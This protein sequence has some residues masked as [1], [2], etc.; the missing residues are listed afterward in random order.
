MNNVLCVDCGKPKAR[1]RSDSLRCRSC[2][3]SRKWRS[4]VLQPSPTKRA[5]VTCEVCGTIFEVI[6]A[7]IGKARTCSRPCAHELKRR[8]RGADHPLRKPPITITCVN[9]DADFEAKPCYAGTVKRFCSRE[10]VGAWVSAHQP[11]VSSIERIVAD[12]LRAA[13]VGFEQQVTVH[14]FV[15]DFVVGN[16]IIEVDGDYWHALPV[17]V[18]RDLRKAVAYADAG[19]ALIRITETEVRRGDFTKLEELSVA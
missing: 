18:A 16:T 11:R 17:V 5:P 7:R 9:C 15:A 12:H 14:Q 2:A 1:P 10:C 6:V 19:F 3:T 8:V 13:G 4:G